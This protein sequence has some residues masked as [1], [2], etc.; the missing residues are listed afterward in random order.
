MV[1]QPV[2]FR[3]QFGYGIVA[4]DKIIQV[5]LSK[6]IVTVVFRLLTIK[7]QHGTSWMNSVVVSDTAMCLISDWFL[8][9]ICF[10]E[11]LT[12]FYFQLKIFTMEV[13]R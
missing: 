11:F 10:K 1:V 9:I 12:V 6:V 2:V 8:F 5:Y 13:R 3:R 7:F 4:D